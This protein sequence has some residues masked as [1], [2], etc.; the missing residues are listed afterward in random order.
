MLVAT[1]LAILVRSV[2]ALLP[3]LRELAIFVLREVEME[4]NNLTTCYIQSEP[5]LF[6]S[7]YVQSYMDA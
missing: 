1:L 5:N 7:G 3:L 2:H 4:I 6:S